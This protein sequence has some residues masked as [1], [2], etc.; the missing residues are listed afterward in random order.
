MASGGSRSVAYILL[1]LN[2][3]LYF[4]VIAIAAWATNHGIERTHETVSVLSVPARIF[5]IYFPLGNMATGMFIIFSLIAGVVG[6]TTSVTGLHNVFEW[7]APN[8]HAAATSSL[9]T[10]ALT[11][12]A[13]G[14]AC[15]EIE[16]GWTDSTLR[17]LETITIIVTA[18][19]LLCTGVIHVGVSEVVPRSSYG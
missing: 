17:T 13:M 8:L 6:F 5:P 19:Q 7:N 1:I 12:L 2:L 16:L 10:W 15:K 3:I 14:F 9:T 4:I 18:T 11:L